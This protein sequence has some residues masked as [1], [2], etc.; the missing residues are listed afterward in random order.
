MDEG[1]FS[2]GIEFS[3]QLNCLEGAFWVY[4]VSL[5]NDLESITED[6]SEMKN[7]MTIA[8]RTLESFIVCA[9]GIQELG[10]EPFEEMLSDALDEH[11]NVQVNK[12]I[13][14]L[15]LIENIAF[16]EGAVIPEQYVSGILQASKNLLETNFEV[17]VDVDIEPLAA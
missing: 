9:N 10:I 6:Y 3:Y 11:T 4:D 14:L 17:Q 7:L 5:G 16:S 12:L 1:N 15:L 2:L 13:I 8:K